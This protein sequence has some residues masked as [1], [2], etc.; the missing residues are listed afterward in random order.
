MA[1]TLLRGGA[2]LIAALLIVALAALGYRAWRQHEV[3]QALAINS[4]RGISEAA[5]VAIGG[6]DQFIQIR[7][8]DR[9]NPVI[10]IL[11]GGPGISMIGLTP[12]FQ[13]WEKYF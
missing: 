3:A 9:G 8:E 10:L 4:P 1:R 2:V 7:G 5:F 6:I 12:I 13:P 11:Q